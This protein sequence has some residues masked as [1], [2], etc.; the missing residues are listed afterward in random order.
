MLERHRRVNFLPERLFQATT[1]CDNSIAGPSKKKFQDIHP[2]LSFVGWHRSCV[3]GWQ[4][5]AGYRRWPPSSAVC[6][7]SN[8]LGQE[9]T[10]P[11]RSP[12]FCHHRANAV[13]QSAWTAS[14][15]GP[16]LRTIQTII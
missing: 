4:M 8:M 1:K 11:V 5:Y 16:Q 6:W 14:A 3:P 12:V 7:Q 9:V 13:E 15:T 2:C 10:Q